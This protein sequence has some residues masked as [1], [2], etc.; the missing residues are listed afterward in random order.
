MHLSPEK[1][2]EF[3]TTLKTISMQAFCQTHMNGTE[4][5]GKVDAYSRSMFF[6]LPFRRSG[7]PEMLRAV[8]TAGL[9]VAENSV[10]SRLEKLYGSSSYFPNGAN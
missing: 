4:G 9:R 7:I 8:R 5:K 2:D 3:L 6:R 10:L 1:I